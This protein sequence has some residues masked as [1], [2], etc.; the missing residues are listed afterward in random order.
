MTTG[1][2]DWGAHDPD[3]VERVLAVMLLQKRP[4]AWRRERSRGDGG[5]DVADPQHPGYEVFQIK[6]FTGSLTG[7]RKIDIENSY[8]SALAGGEL[9][10]PIVS[11][12]L[13]L[14]MDPSKE[15][16][17]WFKDLTKA[18]P[19]ECE[20]LGK[21]RVDLLATN[22]P[23]V[24]DYYLRDGRARIEQRYRD[25][26][27]TRDLIEAGDTG[28]RPAEV[29][30]GLR[31]LLE[32]L[33][34]DDP[35]YLYTFEASHDRP[36]VGIDRTRPGLVMAMSDCVPDRGCVTIRVFA[37]HR[38]AV[39]ERP[40]TINFGVE[41]VSDAHLELQKAFDFGSTAE[42]PEGSVS[43]LTVDAPGGLGSTADVAGLR[44]SGHAEEDFVPFR[45]TFAVVDDGGEEI[46]RTPVAVTERRAG[47]RGK[48]LSCVEAS[49]AF[50]LLM[51]VTDPSAGEPAVTLSSWGPDFWG[52][53]A[54]QVRDGVSLLSQLHSPHR[55]VVAL[56]DG[57]RHMMT[58][59]LKDDEPFL[60]R[61]IAPLVRDLASIQHCTATLLFVP[62][63]ITAGDARR[64]REAAQLLAGT[65]MDGEWNAGHFIVDARQVD[66]FLEALG[67]GGPCSASMPYEIKVGTQ[68][69]PLGQYLLR[70][71]SAVPTN[72][73]AARESVQRATS[74]D[75]GI[76]IDL[77]PAG[78]KHFEMLWVDKRT[79]DS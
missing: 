68:Q 74:T 38:H 56:E 17:K 66:A 19:F 63:T 29:R 34:R 3:L 35:H 41:P 55:L 45:L 22:N 7:R 31:L 71:S 46:A 4:R 23:H 21:S 13:L 59:D 54:A 27:R 11:W 47:L 67:G 64:A 75:D 50:S 69:V 8:K 77:E 78:D 48:E 70:L 53:P 40:I 9:D 72:P 5:V 16:E 76:R 49:G 36:P 18:A 24:V 32:A 10:G 51:R 25:L 44:L 14:P 52:K 28:P 20:W 62:L 42:L 33:N 79:D 26:L 30:E 43:K 6:S 60:P 65:L 37:R 1:P 15:A 57:D 39:E 58:L 61:G 2:I 73:A 12:R